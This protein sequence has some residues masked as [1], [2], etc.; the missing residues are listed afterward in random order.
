MCEISNRSVQ[1][2]E[3]HN[4]DRRRYQNKR[5]VVD[6]EK[7]GQAEARRARTMGVS[8]FSQQGEVLKSAY[9]KSQRKLISRKS[10]T[11]ATVEDT[12]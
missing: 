8:D 11:N 6:E 9:A 7:G 1:W 2:K 4:S 12:K 3:L 5:P 10:C